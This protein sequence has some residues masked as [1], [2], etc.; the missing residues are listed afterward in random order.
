MF[1]RVQNYN[2]FPTI[3]HFFQKIS[4]VPNLIHHIFASFTASLAILLKILSFSSHYYAAVTYNYYMSKLHR[5]II[6]LLKHIDF[7]AC[8][9]KF[10]GNLPPFAYCCNNFRNNPFGSR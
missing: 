7:T 8:N 1:L 4:T 2:T 10:H 5:L 6:H 9:A 3:P